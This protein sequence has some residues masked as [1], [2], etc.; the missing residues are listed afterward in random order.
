MATSQSR[1][2]IDQVYC[3]FT[4]SGM[5]IELQRNPAFVIVQQQ[6]ASVSM[7]QLHL[8]D[9]VHFHTWWQSENDDDAIKKQL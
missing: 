5:A 6:A 4:R 2:K 7:N 1:E 8:P 9:L 3:I